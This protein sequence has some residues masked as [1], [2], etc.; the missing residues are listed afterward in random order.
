MG[1]LERGREVG[2]LRTRGCTKKEWGRRTNKK[3]G[4]GGVPMK[5]G[6][7]VTEDGVERGRG[8]GGEWGR[9]EVPRKKKKVGGGG[10]ST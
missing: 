3:R 8:G 9:G 1:K 4:W 10:W 6:V 7:A 5:R 2:V